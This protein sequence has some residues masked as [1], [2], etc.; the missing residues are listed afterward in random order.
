[1]MAVL[2][3]SSLLNVAYLL[4]IAARGFFVPENSNHPG[5]SRHPSLSKEGK[6]YPIHS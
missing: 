5:A 6:K 4:P 2:L 1:M 3:V